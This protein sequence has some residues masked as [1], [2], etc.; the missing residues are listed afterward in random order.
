MVDIVLLHHLLEAVIPGTTLVFV[1][2]VDQLP[3]VGP[4]NCLKDIITSASSTWCGSTPSSGRS[5]PAGS[6]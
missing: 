2:D 3:S 6:S 1:G 4:G 5:S